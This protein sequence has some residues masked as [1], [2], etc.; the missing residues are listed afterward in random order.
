MLS[1]F[2]LIIKEEGMLG[3]HSCEELKDLIAHQFGFR[4]HEF[5]VY[6]SCPDPFM[7]IF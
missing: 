1:N 5:Y 3:L 6:R 2:A 7:I 4:K